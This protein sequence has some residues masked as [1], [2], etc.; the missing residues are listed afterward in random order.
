MSSDSIKEVSLQEVSDELAAQWEEMVD[1]ADRELGEVRIRLR[2]PQPE[3]NL[4]R[5]A[6]AR[7]G[8]PYQTYI[9]QAAVRQALVDLKD[10]EDHVAV[11]SPKG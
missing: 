3:I 10:T 11:S 1:E 8:I 2:W 5:Q 4:I 9:R 7:G 6:A